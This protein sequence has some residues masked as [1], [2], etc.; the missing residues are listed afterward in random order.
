M[1][2]LTLLTTLTCWLIAQ[3]G[4]T[5]CLLPSIV[6]PVRLKSPTSPLI[7][8]TAL[9]F[10]GVACSNYRWNNINQCSFSSLT[11]FCIFQSTL[12]KPF[13]SQTYSANELDLILAVEKDGTIE[14]VHIDPAAF[15]GTEYAH[16]LKSNTF[17]PF[18]YISIQQKMGSGPS[19]IAQPGRCSTSITLQTTWSIRRSCSIW[20]SKGSHCST[21]SIS[22]CPAPSS[23]RWLYW[24]I[25]CLRKVSSHQ[26]TYYGRDGSNQHHAGF[27]Y[28]NLHAQKVNKPHWFN[29]QL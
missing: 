13:R 12:P 7:I 15:T 2:S 22:S 1:A 29:Q 11:H 10:S 16:S 25:S 20:L 26:P 24:P 4:C 21:S 19:S 8:K 9:W 17:S 18:D 28:L 27:S 14:W 23:P 5:G 6:A 3:V